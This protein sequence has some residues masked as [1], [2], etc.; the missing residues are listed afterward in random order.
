[1]D[2]V[3]WARRVAAEA[4]A[5]VEPAGLRDRAEALLT[6]GSNV[7]AVL[8]LVSARAVDPDVAREAVAERAA[9]VQL[10]YDGLGLTRRLSEDEPWTDPT[11]DS[12][13][14]DLDV[15][16]ADVLVARGFYLLARTE[17][18][19]RAVETVRAFGRD[20]TA[21]LQAT[22]ESPEAPNSPLEE[23][24][25]VMA[26]VAGA[27]AVGSTDEALLHRSKELARRYEDG[28]LPSA[29]TVL[30]EEAR[31]TLF[32]SVGPDA[33]GGDGPARSATESGG[34]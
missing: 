24:V 19:G 34:S 26:A 11:L 29:T 18:A 25:F 9:G 3:V 30:D 10:I 14:A 20:Q 13:Q 33:A 17:A 7:P 31:E 6:N 4:L 22:Q 2:D 5:D 21:R 32:A 15:L 27:T 23:S 8:T 1:M 16:V 12:E 28:S